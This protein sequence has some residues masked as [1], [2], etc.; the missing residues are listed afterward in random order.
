MFNA[1]RS[2][3]FMDTPAPERS[4]PTASQAR[5]EAFLGVTISM[6]SPSRAPMR[7]RNSGDTDKTSRPSSSSSTSSRTWTRPWRSVAPQG[8][9]G[10]LVK[11][12]V[13][14]DNAIDGPC[15][16]LA[17][18]AFASIVGHPGWVPIQWI[19]VTSGAHGALFDQVPLAQFE[20]DALSGD[21]SRLEPLAV[22]HDMDSPGRAGITAE[23]SPRRNHRRVHQASDAGRP[24]QQAQIPAHAQ[25]TPG[26]SR[27]ATVGP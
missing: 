2:P 23:D 1:L 27:P 14:Q 24:I 9:A 20:L 8:T 5:T 15:A 26:R 7:R 19:A 21:F 13:G 3:L 4:R 17:D 10:P 25:A 16:F 6:S 12:A 11:R 22:A 18:V